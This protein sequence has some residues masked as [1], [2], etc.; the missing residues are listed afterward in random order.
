M[1]A[2]PRSCQHSVFAAAARMALRA[3]GRIVSNAAFIS[4]R[5]APSKACI[6]L[7]STS[8]AQGLP[9][10]RQTLTPLHHIGLGSP[11]AVAATH[12]APAV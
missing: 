9:E 7:K 1:H 8:A 5:P 11:G 6:R 2:L 3:P 12:H 4:W 10:L